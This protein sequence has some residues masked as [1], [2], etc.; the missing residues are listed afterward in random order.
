MGPSVSKTQNAFLCGWTQER[1]L[2][3]SRVASLPRHPQKQHDLGEGN[4]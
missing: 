3:E 4:L 1:F 2:C